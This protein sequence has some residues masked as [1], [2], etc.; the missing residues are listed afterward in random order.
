MNFEKKFQKENLKLDKEQLKYTNWLDKVR[1]KN[2]NYFDVVEN[3][4]PMYFQFF[5]K[6]S[7]KRTFYAL[8]AFHTHLFV[9][10]NSIIDLSETSDIYSAKVLYR[11]FIEHWLKGSYIWMRYIKEKSDD[12]GIEYY[13]LGRLGEE[14]KYGNSIK[15]VSAIL[16]AE[17]KNL[18]VCDILCK[19][20]SNLNK[21]NKKDITRNIKKFEYK[22]IVK[23]LV[24]SSFLKA[25]WVSAIV[26]EYSELSSFVHGGPGATEQYSLNLYKQFDEYKGMI[27]FSFNTCR[28][29]TYSV[30][31][32]M[33]KEINSYEKKQLLLLLFKLQDK[34]GMI[35]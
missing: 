28:A 24:G 30:F 29:F 18:D 4:M 10:K 22:N 21:L 12:V 23:Y 20:D 31:A 3:I 16:D 26:P 15:Q 14:L 19:Y 8:M 2:N 17:T 5:K 6:C 25:N 33:L 7:H 11:I 9:L 27:K 32:L 34:N 35:K 13:S 1:E